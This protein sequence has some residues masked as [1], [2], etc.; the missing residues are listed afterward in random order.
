MSETKDNGGHAFPRVTGFRSND[1][2]HT[3]KHHTVDSADGMSL[4]DY[5]A[6]AA[7]TGMLAADKESGAVWHAFAGDAYRAADAMLKARKA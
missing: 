4:R 2:S 6:A 7:L 1:Q 5:F 3:Y